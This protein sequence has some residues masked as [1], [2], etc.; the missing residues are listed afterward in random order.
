MLFGY[1]SLGFSSHVIL[2]LEMK[3][4]QRELSFILCLGTIMSLIFR[5][6]GDVGILLNPNSDFTITAMMCL[7]QGL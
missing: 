1:D 5:R 6:A 4:D 2:Q 7:R 3:W